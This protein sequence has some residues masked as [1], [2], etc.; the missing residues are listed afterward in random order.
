MKKLIQLAIALL[1]IPATAWAGS[2][3]VTFD[4]VVSAGARGCVPNASGTV[5]IA[6]IGLVEHMHVSVSGLPPNTEFAFFVTQLPT[7][8]FGIS[9]FQGRI[10]TNHH[11]QGSQTFVGTFSSDTFTVAPG[12]GPA[13]VVHNG[14][15]PDASLNPPFNPIQMYHLG[16]WFGSPNAAAAAGC[17][18]VVT[19]FNGEHD[20]GLQVLNTGNFRTD[21]GPL[22]EVTPL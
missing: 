22:R 19:P 20:A 4:M 1:V 6:S 13:P 16:L 11:G 7:A 17:P 10:E 3:P 21:R 9:W 12:S 18:A 14:P 5:T 8:P 15:F 2:S